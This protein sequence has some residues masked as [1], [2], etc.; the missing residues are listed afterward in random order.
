MSFQDY[1]FSP[2]TNFLILLFAIVLAILSVEFIPEYLRYNSEIHQ[3]NYLPQHI[4]TENIAISHKID[5]MSVSGMITNTSEESV[6]SILLNVEFADSKSKKTFYSE[7]F[8]PFG[9]SN[10]KLQPNERRTFDKT[11]SDKARIAIQGKDFSYRV[12]LIS[13]EISNKI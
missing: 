6:T 3:P 12:N 2:V 11:L 8:I 10:E 1:K 7:Q 9:S 13:A 4:K 5:S